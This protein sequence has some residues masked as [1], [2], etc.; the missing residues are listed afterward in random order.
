MMLW[1]V[2]A[3]AAC[4]GQPPAPTVG[5]AP[6]PEVIVLLND[7]RTARGVAALT[8]D[9]ALTRAAMAH[10]ADMAAKGYFDHRAPDGSTPLRRMR[11]A[12][13][14]ACYAAE[15]IARGQR[16]GAAVMDSWAG[17]EGHRRKMFSPDPRAV[18]VA[19]GPKDIW[20]M[21]LARA[22]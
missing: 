6:A 22:C 16:S 12:G 4:T 1:A 9:P 10:V 2:L 14:D 20:V 11:A 17:S 3:L 13:F 18:G 21:T 8:E 19:R 15:N 7:A 5:A